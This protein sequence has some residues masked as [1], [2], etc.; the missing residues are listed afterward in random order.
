MMMMASLDAFEEAVSIPSKLVY[1]SNNEHPNSE[2]ILLEALHV[3]KGEGAR[4]L[5]VCG[6]ADNFLSLLADANVESVV[7]VDMNPYQ[8]ALGQLK[9]ALA[10][11]DVPT[12]T[13]LRFL[14]MNRSLE[15][16]DERLQLYKTV[17]EPDLP[18]LVANLIRQDLMYEIETGIAQFGSEINSFRYVQRELAVSGFSAENLWNWNTHDRTGVVGKDSDTEKLQE[19]CRRGIGST[20]GMAQ[21]AFLDHSYPETYRQKW[22][23]ACQ[24]FYN[25]LFQAVSDEK[26]E[27]TFNK[28]LMIKGYYDLESLPEWLLPSVRDRIRE[29]RD[30]VTFA[31]S[32]IDQV[33][34]ED[35]PFDFINTSNLFDWM[36]LQDGAKTLEAIAEK[37]SGKGCLLLRMAFTPAQSLVELVSNVRPFDKVSPEQ[38]AQA[39]YSHFWYQNPEG[40]AILARK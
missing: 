27:K 5:T 13:I 30:C 29:R 23:T 26:F 33:S 1:G 38:L 10:C 17:I 24:K 39:D 20:E 31:Q 37:L 21:A 4:V 22:G 12:E 15:N 18:E 7:C 36:E 32:L 8:L 6:G 16:C 14:G 34:S 9:L 28:A 3:P 40:I 2:K 25:A 11:S 19:V 35:A